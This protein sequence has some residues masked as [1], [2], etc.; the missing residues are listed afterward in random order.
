[1][2]CRIF[3]ELILFFF[4]K[5]FTNNADNLYLRRLAISF[6]LVK[7]VPKLFLSRDIAVCVVSLFLISLIK[8]HLSLALFKFGNTSS[9]C[10]SFSCFKTFLLLLFDVFENFLLK[11]LISFVDEPL[12]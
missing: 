9:R 10:F 4:N 1:M 11:F 7:T 12:V 2:A 3:T 6:P 8:F 5:I